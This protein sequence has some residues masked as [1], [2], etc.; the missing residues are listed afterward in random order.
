MVLTKMRASVIASVVIVFGLLTCAWADTTISIQVAPNV[1]NLLNKAQVVT[2]HTDIAYSSVD[3]SEVSLNDV[4]INSW[5]AD[6]RGNFVAKFLME[7]IK[8]LPLEIGKLNT[9]TLTGVTTSGESFSGSTEILIVK[10]E[11]PEEID[12]P[13]SG[14]ILYICKGLTY[15]KI[16]L[17]C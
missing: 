1:L 7:D 9:L 13:L 16:I 11:C 17:L 10:K 3:A 8:D 2:V 4:V 5:K 15:Q 6:N 14:H 12:R